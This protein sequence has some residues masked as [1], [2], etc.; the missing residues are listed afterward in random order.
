MKKYNVYLWPGCG[1]GLEEFN[2][3]A[4]NEYEA[5]DRLTACLINENKSAYY[6]TLDEMN[7]A[8]AAGS[9]YEIEPDEFEG[10]MYVDATDEGAPYPVY[11]RIENAKIQCVA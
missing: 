7:A 4:L 6:M 3:Q 11:L 8:R 2:I 10:W 9:V 5:L 1:Y